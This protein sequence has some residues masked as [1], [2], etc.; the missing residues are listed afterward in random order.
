MIS[1]QEVCLMYCGE[2]DISNMDKEQLIYCMHIYE[3]LVGV[4]KSAQDKMRELLESNK[5]NKTFYTGLKTEYDLLMEKYNLLYK[6]WEQ[7]S[8]CLDMRPEKFISMLDDLKE[9]IKSKGNEIAQLREQLKTSELDAKRYKNDGIQDRVKLQE[10]TEELEK[11]K[12]LMNTP[13]KEVKELIENLK[14]M[15]DDKMDT[16]AKLEANLIAV[17]RDKE[18]MLSYYAKELESMIKMRDNW[19]A[20]CEYSEKCFQA[21]RDKRWELEEEVKQL[22]KQLMEP[23]KVD[24][25][26]YVKSK[27]DLDE[28]I[29]K[30]LSKF[31][32]PYLDIL[33]S[34]CV[35]YSNIY[36]VF[37]NDTEPL[38]FIDC[39]RGN[40]NKDDFF[41]L[42]NNVNYIIV[43]KITGDHLYTINK[44]T[45]NVKILKYLKFV[46]LNNIECKDCDCACS[47]KK[48]IKPNYTQIY[49]SAGAQSVLVDTLP[50]D[51]RDYHY[52]ISEDKTNKKYCIVRKDPMQRNWLHNYSIDKNTLEVKVID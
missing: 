15:N 17:N 16:I 9:K 47:S 52:Y 12:K 14:Q 35:S 3:G 30:K 48:C 32:K 42:E 19:K 11:I 34:P 13:C 8:K 45:R 44:L 50:Y 7:F 27:K 46:K 5:D 39:I 28:L 2:K 26:C 22:K 31:Q 1:F 37:D 23:T 24:C 43:N 20:D 21:E 41:L 33:Q 6:K 4:D 51:I 10:V 40:L 36:M 25:S 29:D 38:L 18:M 49:F